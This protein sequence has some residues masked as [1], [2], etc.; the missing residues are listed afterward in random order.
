MFINN[1][2]KSP[3]SR[4]L[5]HFT[6]PVQK[7]ENDELTLKKAEQKINTAGNFGGAPRYDGIPQKRNPRDLKAAICRS[8]SPSISRN[9]KR[10]P[11]TD[12]S[13]PHSPA[14]TSF[15]VADSSPCF[16]SLIPGIHGENFRNRIRLVGRTRFIRFRDKSFPAGVACVVY[17]LPFGLH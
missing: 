7:F 10:K 14:P 3:N 13:I 2:L 5:L 15:P 11:K 1:P 12:R 6:R 16:S 4:T 17:A 9:R 8:V